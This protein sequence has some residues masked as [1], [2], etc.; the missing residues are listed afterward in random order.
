LEV[1][2]ESFDG[3]KDTRLDGPNGDSQELCD[4]RIR[5]PLDDA[6]LEGDPVV[7]VQAL[8]SPSQ[9]LRALRQLKADEG[10]RLVSGQVVNELRALITPFSARAL[11]DSRSTPRINPHISGRPEGISLK[12]TC[13]LIV[14]GAFEEL[15][16]GLL[17][18]VLG[19]SGARP[20]TAKEPKEGARFL[21]HEGLEGR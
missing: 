17:N 3:V 18:Q 5:E 14:L 12:A 11:S 20:E 10:L 21:C 7:L 16:D 6:K 15:Q 19:L 4:L 8:D 13:G 9:H 1:F 2:P